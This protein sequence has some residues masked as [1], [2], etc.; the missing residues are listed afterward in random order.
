MIDQ[1]I[2]NEIRSS[3]RIMVRELGFMSSTLAATDYSPSAVHSLLELESRGS[4]TA[5]QLG[6]ILG[7]EK[8]SISRMLVKLIK[9][10]EITEEQ[11]KNDAR[12]KVLKLTAKGVD[13][14]RKI[15][16]YGEMRVVQAIEKLNSS[17]QFVIAQGLT[18]YAE[19]LVSCRDNKDLIDN[20]NVEIVSGYRAGMIGRIAEMHGIYY[21]ENYNFG[22]F[23]E[24]KVATNL[25]EFCNRLSREPNNIWLAIKNNQIV[26]SVAID[27][28]DLGNNEAH[29]RW[30]ILSDDCRGQGV[31]KKLLKEAID[32]C[33]QKQFAAIQLWTFSGL[34]AA[35][36]LYEN[37]GF[38]LTNEW[39]GDQWGRTML[40]QQFTRITIE[41]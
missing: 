26:G 30:F 3:S 35:R 22:Y 23:F 9:T 8:S 33:D 15:N 21:H 31:G 38:K 5:V 19:S 16:N 2:I 12:L 27:G 40:E 6:Q 39:E 36:K 7:L 1:K 10:G 11:D 41:N 29:L 25:A 17:K 24:G 34:S 14:V 4:L 13:T 32:F 37:F 20:N 18:T 28:E